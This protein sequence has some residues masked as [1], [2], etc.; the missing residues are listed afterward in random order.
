MHACAAP[1]TQATGATAC[2]HTCVSRKHQ[3]LQSHLCEWQALALPAP[4]AFTQMKLC[5]PTQACLSLTQN[6]TLS[7]PSTAL[8]DATDAKKRKKESKLTSCY[9]LKKKRSG[10]PFRN[11]SY[12]C[13]SISLSVQH[14][15]LKTYLY[16]FSTKTTATLK[17]N[18]KFYFHVSSLKTMEN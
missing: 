7:P 17:V 5:A 12:I 1:I 10:Q 3:H 4:L 14:F 15:F 13:L 8:P 9:L 18:R 2:R 16:L 6:H 11:T